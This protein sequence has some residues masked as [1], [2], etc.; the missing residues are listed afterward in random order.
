MSTIPIPKISHFY[1]KKIPLV[2]RGVG[3]YKIGNIVKWGKYTGCVVDIV[4]YGRYPKKQYK[5]RL[6][7]YWREMESYIVMDIFGKCWWP[8]V[9]SINPIEE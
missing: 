9:G 3:R 8:K 1:R 2:E 6:Q 4:P 5:I 7:G